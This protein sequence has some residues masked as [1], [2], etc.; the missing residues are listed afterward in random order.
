MY[1]YRELTPE[2]KTEILQQRQLNGFPTHAPPHLHN[3]EGWFLITAA[4]YEHKRH[5]YTDEQRT[6][7]LSELKKEL[8]AI[9][10]SI[11]GWVVLPNHYALDQTCTS[12]GEGSDKATRIGV[13][14]TH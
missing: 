5:F 1:R 13:P 14:Q 12:S 8:Q 3:T 6:W 11:S 9:N 4:T 7:L 10:V 2:E